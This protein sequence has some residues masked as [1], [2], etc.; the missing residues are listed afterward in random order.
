MSK[1]LA[2]SGIQRRCI[3]GQQLYEKMLNLTNQRNANQ[4]F[5]EIPPHIYYYGHYK[6]REIHKHTHTYTYTH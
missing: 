4:N 5:N 2:Q 1:G 3:N 6:H